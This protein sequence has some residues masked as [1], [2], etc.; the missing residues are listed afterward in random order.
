ML[1]CMVASFFIRVSEGRWKEAINSDGR[2]YFAWISTLNKDHNLSFAYP[3]SLPE[4]H[5]DAF[6]VKSDGGREYNKYYPGVAFLIAPFYA[7]FAAIQ[8]MSQGYTDPY[9][10]SGQ[11]SVIF[12]ALFYLGLGLNFFRLTIERLFPDH[13]WAASF[14]VP[15]LVFGTSLFHYSI[16]QPAMSHVYSF[17]VISAFIW[18]VVKW[19]DNRSGRNLLMAG[20]VLVVIFLIRPTNILIVM[21]VPA[22]LSLRGQSMQ[23]LTVKELAKG[24]G[25]PVLL[26]FLVILAIFKIETGEFTIQSYSGEGFYWFSPEPSNVLFSFR[27]GL[28]IYTP[29]LV[30]AMIG[31]GQMINKNR[32]AWAWTLSYVILTLYII[33]SWWNW[34]YGDSFGHRAFIDIYPVLFIAVAYLINTVGKVSKITICTLISL[35]S[36]LTVIQSYQYRKGILHPFDMDAEKYAAVFLKTGDEYVGVLRGNKDQRCFGETVSGGVFTSPNAFNEEPGGIKRVEEGNEFP[37]GHELRP[38]APAFRNNIYFK[39]FTGYRE[40]VPG[41]ANEYYVVIDVWNKENQSLGYQAIPLKGITTSDDSKMTEEI[42][43]CNITSVDPNAEFVK[44]YLWNKEK[45]PLEVDYFSVVANG[46]DSK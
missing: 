20:M 36:V 18:F 14:L 15:V 45:K 24:L 3:K 35:L 28:F 43:E 41:S 33:S 9:G 27:K 12:A 25:L 17:F 30:F 21:M 42:V 22:L 8:W 39:V 37:V 6:I 23:L 11:F 16:A 40:P 26:A 29:V 1:L 31:I 38:L 7:V 5:A 46:V 44:I 32:T 10:W 34:Y 13:R 19:I 2:G 4:Q